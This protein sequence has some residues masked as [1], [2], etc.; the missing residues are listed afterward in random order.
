MKK[1][2]T[3][4][5]TIL[6]TAGCYSQIEAWS[7]KTNVR[8]IKKSAQKAMNEIQFIP[9][10]AWIKSNTLNYKGIY[11]IKNK[12]AEIIPS[13][14]NARLFADSIIKFH[15]IAAF[16][17][18]DLERIRLTKDAVRI[19]TYKENEN[20][21]TLIGVQSV[22]EELHKDD[23][24]NDDEVSTPENEADKSQASNP[25]HVKV[26]SIIFN[27]DESFND[28]SA[29]TTLYHP[30][31]KKA[32]IGYRFKNVIAAGPNVRL[33]SGLTHIGSYED[34]T[35]GEPMNLYGNL[36]ENKNNNK[37]FS[38]DMSVKNNSKK[39]SRFYQKAKKA[40]IGYEFTNVIAAGESTRLADGLIHIGSYI[41]KKSKKSMELYSK[42]SLQAPDLSIFGGI[43]HGAHRA[44][45]NN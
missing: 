24:G 29:M 10:A 22:K 21:M 25:F 45:R 27:A 12:T 16:S 18:K 30:K 1:I 43:H 8:E 2:N 4:L 9:D 37:S 40:F 7:Y 28:S 5:L 38:A 20:V 14:T 19:G 33:E 6:I 42:P 44:N 23:E 34:Q 17:K 41:D 11:N 13:S 3:I 31:T 32:S 26:K 36:I 35:S 39:I 15:N